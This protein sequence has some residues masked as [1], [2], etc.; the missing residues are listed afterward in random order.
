MDVMKYIPAGA[1]V[2]TLATADRTEVGRTILHALE[3]EIGRRDRGLKRSPKVNTENLRDD[4]RHKFGEID[5]LEW[6]GRLIAAARD[7]VSGKPAKE[8]EI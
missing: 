2:E 3:V 1:S 5:G 7:K 4:I 6:L 8:D